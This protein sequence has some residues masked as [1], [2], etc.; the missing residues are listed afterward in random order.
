MYGCVGAGCRTGI[1]GLKGRPTKSSHPSAVPASSHGTHPLCRARCRGAGPSFGIC[2]AKR[3]S[4]EDRALLIA[5]GGC[6]GWGRRTGILVRSL[7]V[8]GEDDENRSDGRLIPARPKR[9]RAASSVRF[10]TRRTSGRDEDAHPGF[11]RS[12]GGKHPPGPQGLGRFA[13]RLVGPGDKT[14]G[15][16][17]CCA[18]TGFGDVRP[19]SRP[20]PGPAGPAERARARFDPG[21]LHRGRPRCGC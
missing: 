21:S 3:W 19:T 17:R 2:L 1:A 9:C 5:T 18:F 14:A 10:Q 8:Q 7:A 16:M 4:F 11:E 15:L 6:V 12:P 13:R 20:F